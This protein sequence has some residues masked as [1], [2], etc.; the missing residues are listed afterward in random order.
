M[1]PDED[2]YDIIKVL[3][4]KSYISGLDKGIHTQI[5]PEGRR[6]PRSI[7]QKLLI[8]RALVAKP[9]LLIM[10]DPLQFV[11]ESEKDAIIDYIMSPEHNWTVIIVAD[12]PY[13]NK[14]STQII[15]L[16]KS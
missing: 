1:I 6:L 15:E 3:G 12:Y 16:K 9:S 2:V 5:D 7:I 13:W 8:A 14:K 11:P 10:E 4:L